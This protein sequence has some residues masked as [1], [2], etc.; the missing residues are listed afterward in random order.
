[1]ASVACE[2]QKSENPLS[3]SLAG[4]LPGVTI[5]TPQP[6]EPPPGAEVLTTNLP[7][8][9]VFANATSDSPRPF[10]HVVEIAA[11]QG[12]TNVLYR[13]ERL[14]PDPSGRTTL[15]VPGQLAKGAMYYWRVRAED[16]ANA[17]A[18]SNVAFFAVV[19][20]VVIDPPVPVS[21]I[22]G[23]TT[24]TASPDFVLGN[25]PVSGPAGLVAYRVQVSRDLAFTSI[26]AN[27]GRERSAGSTTTINVGA[28]ENDKLYYW[29][30][31][32]G[33]GTVSSAMSNI[34]SF[35]TPAA[36]PAP[37]PTP[38]PS[39]PN[40]PPAGGSR[41][42]DPPAGQR[43]PLPNMS[44]VVQQ[45]ARDYPAALQNSCQEHG[46][47]WEFMDRLVDRL[48]QYD[49]RW[50]YNWKR[51][52]VGDPSKDVVDYHHGAGPDEGSTEVYIIDVIGGHCGPSPSP[53]W[54][55]VT[56]VTYQGGTI[57]RWTGRGR[58]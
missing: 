18:P 31:W 43:L 20:P 46:G 47:T 6:A 9:L 42:P 32:G 26:V 34:Q 52:N 40:P 58:F 13:S 12:I 16:G 49:T 53:A 8:R 21:P 54:G 10:W 14:N 33:N 24:T 30:A 39:N 22:G 15:V 28:L 23:V 4:P 44:H 45:V 27:V 36:A 37:A 1:M 48:R 7:L 29:R 51:G 56:D 17:S 5:T 57:G 38:G 19:E 41:T 25:A 2:I 35:R 3:P 11:D 55:D 50:G